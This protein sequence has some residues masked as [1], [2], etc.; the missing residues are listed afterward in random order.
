M[1]KELLSAKS[2]FYKV[3]LHCH[4]TISDGTLS[5]EE[6]KALYKAHGYSAVAFTDHDVFIPH[7][8]LCDDDFIALNGYEMEINAP[9]PEDTPFKYKKTCHMCLV[10][11]EPDN[12]TAVCWHRE[13]FIP[14]KSLPS[15]HL[16]KFDENEPDYERVYSHEGISD[17][18]TR[19][20]N[21]GFFVSYNHPTWSFESYNDYI[22]YNGMHAMEIVNNSCLTIGYDEHNERVY[23]DML[24]SGKRIFCTAT[25]DNHRLDDACGAYVMVA[26]EKLEYSALTHALLRGDFY[27]SEGPEIKALCYEN[28]VMHIETSPV[29]SIRAVC[30]RRH[31]VNIRAGE[32]PLTKGDFKVLEDDIYVRFIITDEHGKKAYTNAYFVD[33]LMS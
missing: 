22:G 30:G 6:V 31:A 9:A 24:R 18:M 2:N 5:P 21:G 23:D 17:M 25:D 10:A 16:V 33:E 27:A 26:A 32:E 4:T 11:I 20:R 3:N 19:G 12:H 14:Q 7:P 29:A 15:K 13:K 1:Y 28:G 8:E